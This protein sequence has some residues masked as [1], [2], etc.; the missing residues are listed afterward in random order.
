MKEQKLMEMLG[1]VSPELIE[2]YAL[3]DY[4]AVT[5][6]GHSARNIVRSDSKSADSKAE[7]EK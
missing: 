2:K 4:K 1:E 3:P 6:P 5:A 7:P